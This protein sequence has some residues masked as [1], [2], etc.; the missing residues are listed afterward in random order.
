MATMKAVQVRGPEGTSKLWNVRCP[1]R[2][3]DRYEFAFKPAE[4]ATATPS[5]RTESFLES[6]TRAFPDTRWRG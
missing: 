1:S 3:P 6:P 2:A 5:P 4:S